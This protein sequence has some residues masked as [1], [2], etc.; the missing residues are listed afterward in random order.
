MAETPKKAP[1]LAFIDWTRGLAAF[2]MLQG[3]SFHSFTRNDL[4]SDGPY[5]LSQ[6]LGGEAP[7]L[8]LFLTG[9]TFAFLM[10]SREKQ[11]LPAWER[12]KAALRRSGYL[13]LLAFAF[14][15]SLFVMGFPGS[16]ASELLRV[17]ILNCMG[18]T[19][20]L[21]APMAVFSTLD[22]VRLCTILGV[23]IAALSPLVSQ[24]N[25]AQLP[26]VIQAYF[27]PSY[28]YFGFFPWG[29]F[30]A[31]GMAAGSVFRLVKKEDL[32]KVAQWMMLIGIGL[33]VGSQYFSS[34][35]YTIY[36]KSEYWLDSPALVV[37]KL[38]V[39]LTILSFAYVWAN[40]AIAH[41]WSLFCQ[42]GTT[43]LLVYWVHIELVY[44]RWF[45]IWK[46][47]LTN[48]QV[49]MFSVILIALMTLLSVLRTRGKFP[50]G[51]LRIRPLATSRSASG[52]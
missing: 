44:G 39:V 9:I 10:H 29:S 1:R 42:L 7:A 6:F 2:I 28:N 20:L 13:F 23:I 50:G 43:S 8:F 31:F 24:L 30:L 14:R 19:M 16:P 32:G 37:V 27:V 47:S 36:T 40:G 17:D 41:R 12:V 48:V 21:L 35:P 26:W 38:G 49:V 5:V 4:R 22:R 25:S 45:G 34:L 52:D 15:V 33:I 46:E 11:G 18:L 3:H 51:L